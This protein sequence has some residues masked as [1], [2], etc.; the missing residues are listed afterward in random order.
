MENLEVRDHLEMVDRILALAEHC[1]R[2]ATPWLYIVWGLAG[3]VL[4]IVDQLV[5]AQRYTMNLLYLSGVVLLAAVV[6]T[7]AYVLGARNAARVSAFERQ[8]G[9]VFWAASI[10]GAVVDIGG[11]NLFSGWAA[12]AIWSVVVAVPLLFVGVQGHRVTLTGGIVLL[13]SVVAANFVPAG[14]TGYVLA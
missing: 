7:V 12:A 6:M 10:A 8:I 3:A 5:F 2:P 14:L 4:D 11:G 13:A 9:R 1:T